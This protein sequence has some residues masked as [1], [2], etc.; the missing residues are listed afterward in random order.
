ML[1]AMGN[2]RESV[3]TTKVEYWLTFKMLGIDT[4]GLVA[5]VRHHIYLGELLY[6]QSI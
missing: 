5:N 3:T 2:N 6:E 1:Q 4:S